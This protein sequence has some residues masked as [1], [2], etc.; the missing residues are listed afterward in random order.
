MH[1]A[2][3]LVVVSSIALAAVGLLVGAQPAA[4]SPG[5]ALA[6]TGATGMPI[7]I[8]IVGGIVVLAGIGFVV[9]SVLSRRG[10]AAG[11]AAAVTDAAGRSDVFPEASSAPPTAEPPAEFGPGQDPRA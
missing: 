6:E 3:R 2:R 7:W 5:S 11:R 8:W 10:K 1:S 4:A 9:F